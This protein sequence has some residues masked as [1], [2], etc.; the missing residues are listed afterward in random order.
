MTG[1]FEHIYPTL[2]ANNICLLSLFRCS[3]QL[4]PLC[5]EPILHLALQLQL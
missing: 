2:A 4:A 3:G 1:G 5:G